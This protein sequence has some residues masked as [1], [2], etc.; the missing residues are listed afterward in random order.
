M[1]PVTNITQHVIRLNA[2]RPT[3]DKT[4]QQNGFI[5]IVMHLAWAIC[6]TDNSDRLDRRSVYCLRGDTQTNVADKLL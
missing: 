6:W 4:G 2:Y 5:I 3:L 1:S